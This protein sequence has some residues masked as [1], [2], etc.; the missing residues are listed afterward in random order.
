MVAVGVGEPAP[1]TSVEAEEMRPENSGLEVSM[2]ESTM[3]IVTPAPV[4]PIVHAVI[5]P[6]CEGRSSGCIPP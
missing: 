6:C 1:A 3:P 2:P 4:A 5:A